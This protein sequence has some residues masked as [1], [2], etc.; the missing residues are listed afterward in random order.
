MTVK[1]GCCELL[2]IFFL[3]ETYSNVQPY[4]MDEASVVNCLRSLT[5]KRLIPTSTS[6]IA[7]TPKLWIAYDLWLTRDLFQPS[8]GTLD[9]AL[10]CE[11]L[12][13]FDLQETYSNDRVA[14]HLDV[15]V[16]NCLRSLTY[17]RLIPTIASA[18]STP[19]A[20][21]IAYDLW[22]TRDLFQHKNNPK[23]FDECCELLTIFDLQET[24]SNKMKQ[25]KFICVVVNC[26]R[27]LTY[28]RLI[29]T[30]PSKSLDFKE[31]DL[32]YQT[33]NRWFM[34]LHWGI[35][36]GFFYSRIIPTA[37]AYRDFE[38][39]FCHDT[40]LYL[41]TVYRWFASLPQNQR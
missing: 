25:R 19:P 22:L 17:K 41:R 30:G 33:K 2:T 8:E 21:W 6:E 14:H 34:P 18:S 31:K 10:G 20:L 36:I 28:K 26:L 9:Y 39:S 35:L 37:A 40:A 27:S 38:S 24:Y 32:F 13:I 11:L 7:W 1:M 3:Q 16:V 15:N 23:K 29:P 4:A 12:T 5:Y